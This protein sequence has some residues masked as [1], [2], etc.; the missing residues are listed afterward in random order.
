MK[1][2]FCFPYVILVLVICTSCNY[3]PNSIDKNIELPSDTVKISKDDSLQFI[4]FDTLDF[5][6]VLK[7]RMQQSVLILT[8]KSDSLS[9]TIYDLKSVGLTLWLDTILKPLPV[10][11]LPKHSNV[12]YIIFNFD[13]RGQAL[14]KYFG[15]LYINESKSI[16]IPTKVIICE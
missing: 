15:K 9:I 3:N 13:A 7:T 6:S 14:G 4:A 16:F 10:T 11:I 1:R 5:G 12:K 8:N 2:F